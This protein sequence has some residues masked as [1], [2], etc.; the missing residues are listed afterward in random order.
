M[1]FSLIFLS[2]MK[3]NIV[4]EA[5]HRTFYYH[6]IKVGAAPVH[7]MTK[8]V[9]VYHHLKIVMTFIAFFFFLSV[10]VSFLLMLSLRS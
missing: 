4:K 1:K 5:Y 10:Q 9:R 3:K 2:I 7:D 6:N 8:N